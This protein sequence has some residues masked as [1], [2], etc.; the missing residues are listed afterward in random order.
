MGDLFEIILVQMKGGSA[1]MPTHDDIQRLKT[2]A[3]RYHAKEVVLFEWRQRE[4]KRTK[5][6]CFSVLRG[7][8]WKESA[9]EDI[10]G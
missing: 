5:T 3:K 7:D 4:P 2:V 6:C 9:A 10:F 1:D 8:D